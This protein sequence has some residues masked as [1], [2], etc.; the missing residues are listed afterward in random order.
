MADQK[1]PDQTLH[2]MMAHLYRGEMNRMTVWRQRLDITSNWAI[3]IT[4]GLTT[5]TLGSVQVPHFIL[6]L[7][8][9]IIAISL[10]IEAQRY[11]HLHH[12]RWRL[13]VMETGYFARVLDPKD[14]LDPRHWREDLARDLRKPSLLLG[15]VD[16]VKVRLRRDYLMLFY[17]I[18]AVWLTKLFI[19]PASPGTFEEFYGRLAIGG[20]IPSWFVALTAPLFLAAI[21]LTAWSSPAP[22][23]LEGWEKSNPLAAQPPPES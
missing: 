15:W 18:M 10:L 1:T 7:G 23:E 8:I 2:G 19:H 3:L 12:S 21:S 14:D 6:L 17:F 22:E 5:F 20:I 16:A 9:D 13:R 4:M 11:R